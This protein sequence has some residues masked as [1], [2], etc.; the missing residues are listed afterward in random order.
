M[1]KLAG[2][3]SSLNFVHAAN[4]L[5]SSCDQLSSTSL[6]PL[7]GGKRAQ[8]I[9]IRWRAD[10]EFDS[11]D[12]EDDEENQFTIEDIEIGGSVPLLR[13]VISGLALDVPFYLSSV[14]DIFV[15]DE[16]FSRCFS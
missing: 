16:T 8:F 3:F 15:R 4:A 13:Q 12:E 10:L 1:T 2:T 9:P 5:R 14:V 7:L 11:F 6:A